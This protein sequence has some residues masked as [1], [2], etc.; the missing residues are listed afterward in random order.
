M[1][2]PVHR[3]RRRGEHRRRPRVRDPPPDREPSLRV[4]CRGPR[5]SAG[6]PWRNPL[7]SPESCPRGRGAPPAPAAGAAG[8]YGA[9]VT[10]P[11]ALFSAV[12]ASKPAR[13]S[14][15][16]PRPASIPIT[17]PPFETQRLTLS[18]PAAEMAEESAP[19]DSRSNMFFISAGSQRSGARRPAVAI[20]GGPALATTPQR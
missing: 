3:R 11:S 19:I 18:I 13:E 4:G 6:Q 20:Q 5:W 1:A 8:G 9:C 15:R 14:A 2:R 16:K 12:V 17:M 10:T 7:R